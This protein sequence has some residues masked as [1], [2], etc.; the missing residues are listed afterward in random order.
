MEMQISLSAGM[1]LL[2]ALEVLD[3]ARESSDGA[4]LLKL[5]ICG[6]NMPKDPF[7]VSRQLKLY[8][9]KCV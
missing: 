8:G 7:N 9:Q 1:P 4:S 3:E 6:F 2:T 5:Q